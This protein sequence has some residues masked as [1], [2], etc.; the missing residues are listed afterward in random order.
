MERLRR[1]GPD[2]ARE[3]GRRSGTSRSP[4]GVTN[5][6]T[7]EHPKSENKLLPS[8][9]RDDSQARTEDNPQDQLRLLSLSADV[10]RALT[11]RDTLAVMLHRCAEALVTHLDAAFARVWTLD[12]AEDVLVL[13]ASAGQYTHLDGPHRRV[14][15]G[16]FKIGLIA[17][18]RGPHLTNTVIGDPR[19]SDQEWAKWEGMVAFAGYPLVVEDRVIGV[20]AL[21]ARQP[22]SNATLQALGSVAD[23]IAVGIERKY[24]EEATQEATRRTTR[25][26]ESI[27]DAFFT[28]ST[29]WRFTYLND[30]AERLLS[31][32]CG[33]ARQE[34]LGRVPRRRHRLRPAVPSRPGRADRRHVRAVLPAPARHLVRG[35]SLPLSRGPIR[36]LPRHHRTSQAQAARADAGGAARPCGGGVTAQPH[37]LGPARLARPRDCLGN[38]GVGTRPGAGG[39]PLLLRRL[40]LGRRHRHGGTRL[41]PRGPADHRGPVPDVALVGM[42]ATQTQTALEAVRVQRRE[43]NIAEQLQDALQPALPGTVPGL[44][45]TKHYE[46][47]LTEEAGVVGH[48]YDVFAIEKGCTALVVGDFSGKGL[49]AANVSVVRNMLRAFLYSKPSLAEAVTE[50]NRVLAENNL[51]TGFATLFVGGTRVLHYVNCGQEPAL[52]RR[53]ATGRVETL[54]LTGPILG[55]IENSE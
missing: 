15:V 29:D 37:R 53:A 11:A 51:L 6:N 19:V 35:Q 25:I 38:G 28:L 42:V 50:L 32:A 22:L 1:N 24:A 27:T 17:Q 3:D 8:Y 54:P 2:R 16:Q 45:V 4:S 5:T 7:P 13:R 34:R 14:P 36:L 12:E 43:H 9:P 26:L 30:Q 40:R 20:V 18:E 52:V 46:A 10:G 48:F 23:Q 55:S 47:A 41:A 33:P 39:G 21:F 44:A 49:V 31:R